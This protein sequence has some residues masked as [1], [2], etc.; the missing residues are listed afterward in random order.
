MAAGCQIS[1][2]TSSPRCV[3]CLVT[4]GVPLYRYPSMETDLQEATYETLCPT[5]YGSF[6]PVNHGACA[7]NNSGVGGWVTT[8]YTENGLT[9]TGGFMLKWDDFSLMVL[10][11][12]PA[13][14]TQPS[15]RSSHDYKTISRPSSSP[16]LFFFSSLSSNISSSNQKDSLLKVS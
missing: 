1:V 16:H 13:S 10:L 15:Q 3:M 6:C 4:R 2:D 9:D 5:R 11:A 12:A 14:P 7:I 8:G